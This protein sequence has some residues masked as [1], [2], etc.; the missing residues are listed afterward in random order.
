MEPL[1]R[2]Y[3]RFLSVD[4]TGLFAGVPNLGKP[5]IERENRLQHN[6]FSGHKSAHGPQRRDVTHILD[7][8]SCFL[9]KSFHFPRL[10]KR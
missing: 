1:E 5:F 7:K 4:P 9:L 3:S 8:V 2:I 6:A 10:Q